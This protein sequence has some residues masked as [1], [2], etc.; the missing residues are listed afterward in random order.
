MVTRVCSLILNEG[1]K[2]EVKL[3]NNTD[4]CVRK[5]VGDSYPTWNAQDLS[6]RERAHNTYRDVSKSDVCD[7]SKITTTEASLPL[8]LYTGYG[9]F[10][11]LSLWTF[12]LQGVEDSPI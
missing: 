9:T 8:H 3:G 2:Q 1:F 10:M 7:A 6:S 4:G 12:E 5:R 11:A